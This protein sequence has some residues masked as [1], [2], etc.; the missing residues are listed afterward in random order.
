MRMR[1]RGKS[2][3][4]IYV[5]GNSRNQAFPEMPG[6]P[7]IA[8]AILGINFFNMFQILGKSTTPR[9]QL[10]KKLN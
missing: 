6:I 1:M 9:I 2:V 3:N 7:A 4:Y 10:K 5:A 8:L